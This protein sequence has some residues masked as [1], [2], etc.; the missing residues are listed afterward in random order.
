MDLNLTEEDQ[1]VAIQATEM[2][3]AVAIMVD[4]VVAVVVEYFRNRNVQLILRKTNCR[5]KL[6]TICLEYYLGVYLKDYR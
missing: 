3:E 6:E 1:V 5:I 2:E 4:V